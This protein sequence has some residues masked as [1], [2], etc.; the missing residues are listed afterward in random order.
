MIFLQSF[1]PNLGLVTSWG[2]KPFWTVLS[3]YETVAS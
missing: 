2:Y 3:E 1:V